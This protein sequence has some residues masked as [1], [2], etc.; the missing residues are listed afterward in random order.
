MGSVAEWTDLAGVAVALL[1]A[2]VV[3]CREL[4]SSPRATRRKAIRESLEILD[5]LS[6][7]SPARSQ[8]RASIDR[9]IILLVHDEVERRRHW[10]GIRDGLLLILLAAVELLLVPA[11]WPVWIAAAIVGFATAAEAAPRRVRGDDGVRT[12]P[13]P[14]PLDLDHESG[15]HVEEGKETY[16]HHGD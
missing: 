12:F 3:L 6:T 8:L 5:L 9:R 1:A 13:R 14:E 10:N 4:G 15:S 2:A 7:D 11:L 16:V